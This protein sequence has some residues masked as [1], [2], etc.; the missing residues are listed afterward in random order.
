MRGSG[1]RLYGGRLRRFCGSGLLD[2]SAVTEEPRNEKDGGEN[3]GGDDAERKIIFFGQ[4]GRALQVRLN[5]VVVRPGGCAPD[6]DGL[7]MDR[8][9]DG[10]GRSWPRGFGLCG[11]Q[12]SWRR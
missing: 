2:G 5:Q 7:G 4:Q 9:L 8:R 12:R 3:D 10:G 6:R 11:G 1:A